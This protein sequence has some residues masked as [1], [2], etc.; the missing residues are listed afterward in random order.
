MTAP[1]IVLKTGRDKSV[2]RW[3][4]WVFSGAI[5]KVL[6]DPQGGDTVLVRSAEGQ[7]LGLAAYSPQSQI[8]GRMWTFD[9][10]A[11]VDAAFLRERVK[12][13]L[14]LSATGA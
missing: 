10:A 2:K 5:E 11:T 4:P 14:D 9:A 6:G 7:Q 3:H 1:V 8:R 13:A 12:R